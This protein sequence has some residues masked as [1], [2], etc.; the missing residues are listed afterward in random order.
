[1]GQQVKV[2]KMSGKSILSTHYFDSTILDLQLS[3]Q[4][5]AGQ[6]YKLAGDEVARTGQV[7]PP[8]ASVELEDMEVDQLLQICKDRGIAVG[9]TKSKAKLIEKIRSAV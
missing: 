3:L 7:A 4:L 8:Q 5:P 2:Y 1:M 6:Y 9:N